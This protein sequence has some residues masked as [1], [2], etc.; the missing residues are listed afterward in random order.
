MS[1]RHLLLLS[2]AIVI[3][4]FASRHARAADAEVETVTVRAIARFGFDGTTLSPADR[5]AMLAEVGRMSNVTWQRITAVGHT[6]SVG[7]PG[8]NQRLS[9]RR[10][11]VVKRALQGEGIDGSMVRTEGRAAR[12][13]VASNDDDAGRAQNRRTEIEFQGV[14]AATR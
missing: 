12:Q 14:R 13:P 9:E 5:S 4:T 10:A 7:S 3:A 6:D 1:L 11:Q 8:Y 2:L